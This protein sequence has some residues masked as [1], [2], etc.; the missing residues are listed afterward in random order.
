ML[1]NGHPDAWK[2]PLPMVF[3]EAKLVA[4]RQDVQLGSAMVLLVKAISAQPNMNVAPAATKRAGKEL[5]KLL[6]GLLNGE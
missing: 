4:R 3:S 2:Y 1:A 6:K 5:E